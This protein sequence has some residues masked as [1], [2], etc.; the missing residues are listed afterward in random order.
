MHNDK[1]W[2]IFQKSEVIKY[3]TMGKLHHFIDEG[4]YYVEQKRFFLTK[5]SIS[6]TEKVR[7]KMG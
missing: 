2:T 1:A 3:M 6:I 7:A 5:E 4:S